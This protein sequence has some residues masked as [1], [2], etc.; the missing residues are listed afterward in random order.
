MT[1]SK[2]DP[3]QPFS[4]SNP[5]GFHTREV[6]ITVDLESY[7]EDGDSEAEEEEDEDEEE[8]APAVPA[9]IRLA[10]SSE[11]AVERMDWATGDIYLE[12]LDH[13][14]GGPNLEYVRDGIPFLLDHDLRNQIGLGTT[15]ELGA[16]RIL[17]TEVVPGNHPD[18]G[19]VFADMAAGIRRKV[20]IGYWPGDTYTE[21]RRADGMR[22]RRYRG[23]TLFEASSVAVPADYAMG[24]G[25]GDKP[26]DEETRPITDFPEAGGDT[27]VSLDNSRYA[28]FPVRE[29]KQLQ[30]DYPSVWA[31]GGNIRGNDQFRILAPVAERGGEPRT[32]AERDAIKL[33]EAWA[34]RHEG[35]FRLPGVIAQVKWLV[36][37][38]RGLEYMRDVIKE[39]TDAVDAEEERAGAGMLA[40]RGSRQTKKASPASGR[41]LVRMNHPAAAAQAT[42]QERTMD[43]NTA[44]VPGTAPASDQSRR[45]ARSQELAVL[46]RNFPT[47]ARLADWIAD[48]VTVDA[49]RDEVMRKL[50]TA[51]DTATRA[52]ATPGIEVGQ[53]RE[54][55]KPWGN[56]AE[57]FRAVRAAGSGLGTDK[58]L[59][60]ER[61]ASGMG[62]Q[63][64]ADGGFLVPE[65]FADNIV[66]LA[67]ETGQVLSRVNRIPVSGNQYHMNLVDET[68]RTTGNRWGGIRGYWVGEGDT[69]TTS[70]PKVRRAT[71]DVTKKLAVAA[72]VTAEALEDAPATS[73][74]L[75][76]AFAEEVA[77]MTEAAIF[78][79]SGAG[80][81]LG[82][83]NSAAFV[84]VAKESSQS[85]ASVVAANVVKMRARLL[86]RSRAN[87][88]FFVH[89]DVEPELQT[90]SIGN[91]PVYLPPGGLAGNPLGQ[92]LGIPVV[93][94]EHC[95]ALGTPG[96]I[97]LADMSYY[98]LGEKA[99][100]TMA[101]SMHV[102]F[103][104]DEETFRM[105]Y[106]VDG[107]PMLQNPVTPNKGSNTLSTFVG[108][109]T[110]P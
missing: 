56:N 11:A 26:M 3:F 90:M 5:A 69:I 60:A 101:R 74:M 106:R 87:A 67:F 91:Q 105:T 72:Y 39:A 43:T 50:A 88:V 108:V 8:A 99:T 51:A 48:G 83:L 22:I 100:S 29:A 63:I 4:R 84:T 81:P 7:M 14:L 45:E 95:E 1:K 16:D 86:P 12:V 30:E 89:L 59:M 9:P 78:S 24:I 36:V 92:L 109:A 93:P 80:Q 31:A 10:I 23:W 57:F 53:D 61:S 27:P 52:T 55:S 6:T 35:D 33:R 49:A 103:L 20:S 85:T 58:R 73:T 110:R 21:T 104:N 47:H 34:A 66:K 13:G 65:Q 98:A 82:I 19:W 64:G 107:F 18:A 17:R 62:V 76:Q 77:F 97:V 41:E 75:D 68:N 96:D 40:M 42:P 102:R 2:Q 25:R 15:P 54:A 94:I 28:V 37:G 38:S 79:G 46:A 44:P 70:K 71:L 32:E